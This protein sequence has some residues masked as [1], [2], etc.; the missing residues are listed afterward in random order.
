MS[1]NYSATTYSI[2]EGGSVTFTLSYV[3]TNKPDGFN[4]NGDFTYVPY[5]AG[6]VVRAGIYGLTNDFENEGQVTS[7]LDSNLNAVFTFTATEDQITEGVEKFYVSWGGRR[8]LYRSARHK[9]SPRNHA[10][11]TIGRWR[12][13]SINHH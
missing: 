12:W 3:N 2:N 11:T 7:V 8:S 9:Q 5:E 10:I 1:N 6:D 4:E 13:W